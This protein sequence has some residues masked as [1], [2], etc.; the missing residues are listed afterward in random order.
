MKKAALFLLG[1]CLS[2]YSFA[3]V[4]LDGL[5]IW[6]SPDKTRVVFDLSA[7]SDY[8][9]LTLQNP[10]RIVI[11]LRNTHAN[12]SLEGLV[13]TKTGI[14]KIRYGNKDNHLRIVL[15]LSRKFKPNAFLLKPYGNYGH[16]L[17]LDLEI[18]EHSKKEPDNV[19]ITPSKPIASM[20]TLLS[21]DF[22]IAIDAGH[23][24]EDPGAIGRTYK[25][26]EK[27]VVLSV[28]KKLQQLI[29]QQPGM[30]ALLIR[31]GDYYVGLRKR[32]Q[33][34]R[35][36]GADLFISLHAD[37]YQ[38]TTAQGASVFV[39]SDHGASSEAARWLAERENRTD[40]IGGVS[41]DDKGDLLASVLLDLSQT[42]NQSASEEL[43]Q[44][45]LKALG[46]V[47]QLHHRTV[48]RAGFVVLKS[49]DVPSIL[50]ELGFLS[51]NKGEDKLRKE[52][53]QKEL[54][55]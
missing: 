53:H 28:A 35:K 11:D 16:R 52:S 54:A 41:L 6:P 2:F 36:Q 29:N 21:R 47:T 39:L 3:A 55:V 33:S 43:G 38:N 17:V 19:E 1:C 12:A 4:Q 32:T 18:P 13:Y 45:I 9:L 23:G 20:N 40:L 15:Q 14:E 24:G 25:T 22:V 5:R 46:K 37:S 51:N 8:K 49:P 10:D 48:Q 50:V 27:D 34:A 31:D 44:L 26:R 7:A 42:A 30:R